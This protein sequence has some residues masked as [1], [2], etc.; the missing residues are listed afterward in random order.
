MPLASKLVAYAF[1]GQKQVR[2]EFFSEFADMHV[3]GAID[4]NGISPPY[5]R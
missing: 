5:L 4:Y 3:D 2:V 1:N